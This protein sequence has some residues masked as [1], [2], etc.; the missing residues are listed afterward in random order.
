MA[1]GLDAGGPGPITPTDPLSGEQA[2]LLDRAVAGDQAAFAVL[3]APYH[4][5]LH[6]HCYR[7]LGSF[8]DAEDVVQEVLVR[9]WRHL[10]GFD[11]RSSVRTWLYRIA[12][13]RCLTRRAR[14]AV[15][16]PAAPAFT[17]PPPNAADVEVVGLQPIPDSW[18]ADQVAQGP[19]AV[20]D[21]AESVDLAFLTAVQLL[22]GR[23]RATLLLRD[24]LGYSAR[25]TADLLD[26]T[27]PGV[28]SLLHRARTTLT[29]HRGQGRPQ[30]AAG[31]P[32]ATGERRLLDR[33]IS[34]WHACDI[35]ALLALLRED[36]VLTM[37]PFP[38]AYRGHAA[39]AG[40]LSTVPAAG[41]LDQIT[42]VPVRANLQPAV[43][44]Y[45]HNDDG[46]TNAYGVMVLTMDGAHIIEITGFAGHSLFAAFGL[47]TDR[48]R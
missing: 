26:A 28:N 15:Q 21:L 22:P 1:E 42:L 46:T 44:A 34:A 35:P 25:E 3:V 9:A 38:A 27:V 43:A 20:Y 2:A 41:H 16:P 12:T 31:R 24:V 4:R 40:F 11:S 30:P 39:I 33:Y 32:D 47:P 37:P 8:Q 19:E 14:A 6:V 18:L 45:V 36:A 10:R 48:R 23:Q 13:N 5:E 7:M 29:Q 17:P